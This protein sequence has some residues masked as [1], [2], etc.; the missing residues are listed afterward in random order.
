MGYQLLKFHTSTLTTIPWV[1]TRTPLSPD[2]HMTI[3][4]VPFSKQRV[5]AN[6]Q[7]L[8]Q[9]VHMHLWIDLWNLL[10][11]SARS[12]KAMSPLLLL[13]LA[14]SGFATRVFTN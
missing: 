10:W 8:R 4:F 2:F 3:K 11:V 9:I 13:S 6:A 5:L 7:L 12:R 14:T 1:Q